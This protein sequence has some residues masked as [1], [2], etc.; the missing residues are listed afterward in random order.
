MSQ[1]HA[2]ASRIINARPEKIYA[3]LTDYRGAHQSILPKPYFAS[4]TV[5]QGGQG[6]G[7]IFL[8]KMEV[9]GNK[10]QVHMTVSEPEPGRVLAEIDEQAGVSTTFTLDPLEGGQ[11][12]RVTIATDARASAGLKGF[13]ERLMT[14]MI[15][16]RIYNAELSLLAEVAAR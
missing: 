10:S 6:A 14:P 16:R 1:F 3:I 2:E 15:M 9:Y 4:V 5:E 7:T 13:V 11:R 8:A 12:T